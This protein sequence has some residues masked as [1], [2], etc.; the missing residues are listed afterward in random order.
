MGPA[1]KK[2]S[3][4]GTNPEESYAVTL[5]S[6]A[7]VRQSRFMSN[8]SRSE[9]VM[10]LQESAHTNVSLGAAYFACVYGKGNGRQLSLPAIYNGA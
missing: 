5:A 10:E 8:E 9:M 2:E 4:L 1:S 7:F 3:G 6:V